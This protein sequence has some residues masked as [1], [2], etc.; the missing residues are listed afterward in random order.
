ML[1]QRKMMADT[2]SKQ[3]KLIINQF[4]TNVGKNKEISVYQF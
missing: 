4:E 3:K 1:K 2:V